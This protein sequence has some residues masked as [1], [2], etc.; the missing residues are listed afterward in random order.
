MSSEIELVEK[1]EINDEERDNNEKESAW[2]RWSLSTLLAAWWSACLYSTRGD[3]VYHNRENGSS[4]GVYM[5]NPHENREPVVTNTRR[6]RAIIIAISV[7]GQNHQ[8]RKRK[9]G[10]QGDELQETNSTHR[11]KGA[12]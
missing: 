8:T 7:G 5:I 3:M 1:E 6:R 9:K 10:P 11:E 12:Q 2:K 4:R